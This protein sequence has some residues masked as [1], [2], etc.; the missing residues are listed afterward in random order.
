MRKT[1]K[2]LTGILIIALLLFAVSGVVVISG[3][4]GL[5]AIVGLY[6]FSA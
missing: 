6:F 2:V 1:D 3:I 4:R 5:I